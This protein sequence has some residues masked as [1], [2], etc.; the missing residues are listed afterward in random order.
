MDLSGP[1]EMELQRKYDE[2]R[3]KNF[4]HRKS[5]KTKAS[6]NAE[7]EMFCLDHGIQSKPN[8]DENPFFHLFPFYIENDE[9]LQLCEVSTTRQDGWH[10]ISI[11]MD[12][13]ACDCVAPPGTFPGIPIMQTT[14]SRDG[15][16]YTAAG[17]H[18]IPNLGMCRP[19]VFTV[20][21]ECNAMAFQMAA[22]SKP[23]GAVSKFE[24]AGYEVRFR[25][26]ERGGSFIEC[27]R[28]GRKTPLRK[29][30]GVYFLDVWMKFGDHVNSQGFR[31]QAP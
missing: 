23:L 4:S 2:A 5:E 29:S 27:E 28:T 22:I 18:R 9:G 24:E 10:P 3:N 1:E 26:P 14:A 13:G 20:D 7:W 12:S 16:E 17:G 19:V 11:M 6:E 31:R 30:G 21:G 15:L 8:Q 25:R